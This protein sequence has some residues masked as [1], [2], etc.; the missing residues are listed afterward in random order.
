M[1]GGAKRGGY[2]N[3]DFYR[4][5]VPSNPCPLLSWGGGGVVGEKKGLN[6]FIQEKN[7]L[8]ALC[9]NPPPLIEGG[10]G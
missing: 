3:I 2:K 4:F 1:R 6:S 7:G 5:Q 10:G 9:G 8:K